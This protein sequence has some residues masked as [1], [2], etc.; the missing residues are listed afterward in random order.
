M[1]MSP[2]SV[3]SYVHKG[4]DSAVGTS[5]RYEM[6]FV[7]ANVTPGFLLLL[8]RAA[9]TYRVNDRMSSRR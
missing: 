6:I 8:L 2:W 5:M 3:S 7:D 9:G 4:F 1:S